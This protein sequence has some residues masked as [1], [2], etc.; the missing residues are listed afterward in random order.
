MKKTLINQQKTYTQHNRCLRDPCSHTSESGGAGTP[1]RWW[2]EVGRS[3][4]PFQR[5]RTIPGTYTVA[6]VQLWEEKEEKA[7]LCRR[8][9]ALG[10]ASH[11]QERSTLRWQSNSRVS[12]TKQSSPDMQP[13]STEQ[14]YG[15]QLSQSARAGN[16]HQRP[17]AYV[18]KAQWPDTK[19]SISTASKSWTQLPD[20][21]AGSENTASAL[22]PVL[23]G[24][25]CHQIL[26]LWDGKGPPHQTACRN[27]LTHQI[28]RNDKHPETNPEVIEIYNLKDSKF[29]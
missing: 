25:I 10:V 23:A 27:I 5:Q 22:T 1:R 11:L 18:Y 4:L 28:E 3:P 16:S 29:K 21:I 2:K 24:G 8:A 7:A 6:S 20:V 14:E 17:C 12:L 9:F 15:Q 19:S 26:P 13:M